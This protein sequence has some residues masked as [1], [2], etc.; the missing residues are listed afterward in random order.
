[1]SM[2]DQIQA[3]NRKNPRLLAEEFGATDPAVA[4]P[5]TMSGQFQPAFTSD[6]ERPAASVAEMAVDRTGDDIQQQ[7]VALQQQSEQLAQA[8]MAQRQREMQS[9]FGSNYQSAMQDNLSAAEA[10]K[11]YRPDGTLSA[12]RQQLL[13]QTAGYAGSPYQFGGRTAKG[14]DCSGLV[15]SVYNSLGFNIKSHSVSG[16]ARSIPGV[17]TSVNNLRPGD[18]VVWGNNS[19]IAIYAGNGQIWDASRSRGTSLRPLWAPQNQVYG[20]AVKLPGE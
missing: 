4:R 20:I 18:L 14:I 17:K 9:A 2:I 3:R 6:L 10:G 12:P 8:R 1:M 11:A 16:Q 13:R 15:M 5:D 19:H 7:N